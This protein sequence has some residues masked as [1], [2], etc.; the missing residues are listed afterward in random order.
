[1]K[2]TIVV[3]IISAFIAILAIAQYDAKD[4]IAMMEHKIVAMQELQ[5]EQLNTATN[6][7]HNMTNIV[8]LLQSQAEI[9]QEIER[10]TR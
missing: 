8:N 3:V 6:D 10:R 2:D 7:I 4:K 9:L 1:M 5:Q